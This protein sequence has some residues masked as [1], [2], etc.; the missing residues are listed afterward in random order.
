MVPN[1]LNSILKLN[2]GAARDGEY[3]A[4]NGI[5]L[6]L[7]VI[8]SSCQAEEFWVGVNYCLASLAI[9]EVCPSRV[10]PCFLRYVD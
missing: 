7:K 10:V 1:A 9:L 6:D 5:G 2:W 4:V 3:G 8:T